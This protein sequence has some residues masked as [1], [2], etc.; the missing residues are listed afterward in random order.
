M[1]CCR[2]GADFSGAWWRFPPLRNALLAGILALVAFLLGHAGVSGPFTEK[3]GYW[4]AIPVGAW[5]W[6]REG[7]EGL[8]RERVI[9]I[10][11][12]MLAAAWWRR[13]RIRKAAPSNGWSASAG[14]TVH[15]CCWL[16]C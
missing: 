8:R 5:Y 10:E 15:S 1:S 12:L 3:L 16:H 6:A 9:S 2:A 14:A 7:L 13:H 11:I 4:L